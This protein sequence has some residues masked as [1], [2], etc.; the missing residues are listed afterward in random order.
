MSTI[1]L[2]ITIDSTQFHVLGQIGELLG[3]GNITIAGPGVVNIPA[4]HAKAE[5]LEVK[6]AEEVAPK[7]AP[8]K[9]TPKVKEPEP[10][11]ETE[12]EEEFELDEEDDTEAITADDIRAVQATKV[13]AHRETII[14]K[15][16]SFGSTGIKDLK[17]ENF[18]EYY[19]F[20]SKLK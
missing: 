7:K 4:G 19:D 16:K 12:D 9:R 6:D 5:K 1:K 20:L 15:L 11:P 13:T 14:K 3:A 10:E 18:R 2:E 8:A 17:E